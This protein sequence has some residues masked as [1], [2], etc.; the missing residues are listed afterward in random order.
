M[1]RID[2]AELEIEMGNFHCCSVAL[3]F[4]VAVSKVSQ[5]IRDK[6]FETFYLLHCILHNNCAS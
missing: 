3:Q 2:D 4:Q 1:K 5:F 6:R